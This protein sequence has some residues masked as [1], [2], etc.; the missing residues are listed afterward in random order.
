MHD[1]GS[2]NLFESNEHV[3]KGEIF[4]NLINSLK[5]SVRVTKTNAKQL[6]VDIM[7]GRISFVP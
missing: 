2:R 1:L 4:D 6:I 5:E 7:K 3:N